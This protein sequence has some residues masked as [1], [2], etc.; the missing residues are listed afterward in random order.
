MV[1]KATTIFDIVEVCSTFLFFSLLNIIEMSSTGKAQ[2]AWSAETKPIETTKTK[3]PETDSTVTKLPKAKLPETCPT[4]TNN[5]TIPVKI[6]TPHSNTNTIQESTSPFKGLGLPPKPKTNHKKKNV[7]P[8]LKGPGFGFFYGSCDIGLKPG[9]NSLRQT[10]WE[11]YNNDKHLKKNIRTM[12]STF[13]TQPK[14]SYKVTL[15]KRKKILALVKAVPDPITRSIRAAS[16]LRKVMITIK[17]SEDIFGLASQNQKNI[18]IKRIQV[19]VRRVAEKWS[20]PKLNMARLWL[21]VVLPESDDM[22][23]RTRFDQF[24]RVLKRECRHNI[25]A[26]ELLAAYL[27]RRC[28]SNENLTSDEVCA[29]WKLAVLS[30]ALH[31]DIVFGWHAGILGAVRIVATVEM[32]SER[33]ERLRVKMQPF[34]KWL[35]RRECE[36]FGEEVEDVKDGGDTDP[37]PKLNL[38]KENIGMNSGPSTTRNPQKKPMQPKNA[39]RKGPGPRGRRVKPK[40]AR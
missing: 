29:L 21:E 7:K 27:E 20:I 28:V 40:T 12:K 26:Q 38:T 19:S 31:E 3:T 25:Q 8:Y 30:G 36:D 24:A 16:E 11:R 39:N 15:R 6:K 5:N 22:G 10:A 37:V 34:I 23:T 4:N 17:E 9:T 33:R 13:S 14:T 35:Q 18:I 32:N 2:A 1:S